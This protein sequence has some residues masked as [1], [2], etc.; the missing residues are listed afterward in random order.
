LRAQKLNWAVS[1][2]RG[3]GGKYL[4]S[5][6]QVLSLILNRFLLALLPAQEPLLGVRIYIRKFAFG[7]YILR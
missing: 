6:K 1:R 5:K 3:A 4:Y 7:K 2:G